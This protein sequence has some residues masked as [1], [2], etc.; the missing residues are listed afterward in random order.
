MPEKKLKACPDPECKGE[1]LE[2]TDDW[3]RILDFVKLS[4]KL[5]GGNDASRKKT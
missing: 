2:D 4:M 5:N 1:S 3:K